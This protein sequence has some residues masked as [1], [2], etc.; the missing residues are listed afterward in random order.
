MGSEHLLIEKLDQFIR[1]FY[2]N[3][4]IRGALL[5]LAILAGCYLLF[6]MLESLFRFDTTVRTLLFYLF[7][8]IGAASLG[9]LILGPLL[10]YLH[11]GKRISRE[12]AARIIGRH[13]NEIQDKLLNALQLIELKDNSHMGVDLLTASID[14]KIKKLRV[15]SFTRTIDYRKNLKYLKFVIP[16]IAIIFL[17]YL[18]VPKFLFEP[19][20]RIVDYSTVYDL[21]LPFHLQV[22]NKN[23][24]VFQQDDFDVKV[25]ASGEEIPSEV[26]IRTDGFTYRMKKNSPLDFSYQFKSIQREATF[27]I[28]ANNYLSREYRIK[29]IPRPTILS[30][31]VALE[32]PPYTGKKKENLEN[33]GDLTV[34][35]GTVILWRW[36]TKDVENVVVKIG[37]REYRLEPSEE[38]LFYFQERC[39]Q[40]DRYTVIP[41]NR[42][43]S[44]TDSLE[45]KL[46]CLEDAYPSILVEKTT[47]P[48][49]PTG[50]FFNGRIRDDYGFTRLEFHYIIQNSVDTVD[51]QE[52]MNRLPA[53]K[54]TLEEVFYYSIDLNDYS[55]PPGSKMSY[56]FMI[57]DNDAI[58]GPKETKSAI[59]ETVTQ[60]MDQIAE[61]ASK[62]EREIE[63]KIE[64]LRDQARNTDKTIDQLK[65][66]LMEKETMDWQEKRELED[67]I[68]RNEE[69]LE[70][71]K[72]VKEENQRNI[73]QEERYLKTSQEI[74]EKKKRL[75]ELMEELMTDEMR[76]TLEELKQLMEQVDK[77]K[78]KE[79]MDQMKMTSRELEQQLDRN[80]ELF[81]QIEF[82]RK[83]EQSIEELRK[84]AEIQEQLQERTKKEESESK[85]RLYEQQKIGKKFDSLQNE[86][87]KLSEME[88]EL[89]QKVGIE[90]TESQQDSIQK[91]LNEAENNL[92]KEDKQKATQKQKNAAQQ[93]NQLADNLQ[94]MQQNSEIEQYAEDL[95]LIRQ[96]MENLI[97]ISFDQ[98]ELINKTR[99]ISRNDPRFQ[100]IITE[101]NQLNENLGPVKDS[102]RAIGKRQM[103]IQPI[104]T[105]ELN[106]IQRNIRETIESMNEK[107]IPVALTKQQYSM[108]SINNLAVLLD[109]AME[110]MNRNMNMSMQGGMSKMC[111]NPKMG[112]GKKSMKTLRQMQQQLSE[113]LEKIKNGLQKRKE[114]EKQKGTEGRMGQTG[115]ENINEEIAR[116]AAEQEAIREELKNYQQYLKEQGDMDQDNLLNAIKKI[117]ENQHDLINKK[118]T[119]ESVKRQQEILTRLLE[120]E[121]AEQKRDQQEKREAEEAKS[122][123]YSNPGTNL[124]YNKYFGRG[125]DVLNYQS[126]PVSV[127]YKNKAEKYLIQISQ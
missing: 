108:T 117:D 16:P 126:L 116:L 68:Q 25:T 106:D 35:K 15:I 2:K 11:L 5:S 37:E 14:Q 84:L 71:I 86:L 55:L 40:S 83:L 66:K 69:M 112:K 82:E 29:V 26:Y 76:K 88:K 32:Y 81:R 18:I 125:T 109:E 3:R 102:L 61:N 118:V 49:A 60:T 50:I 89:E 54:G 115:E 17:A 73:Q 27:R 56:Y 99:T 4:M 28:A 70:T 104:I 105:R 43:S 10:S 122:Q 110:Q 114:G 30:F 53:S 45:F 100:Q 87:S 113:Q 65:R 31:T 90:K 120:S 93:M 94:Q 42:Y 52:G 57:W 62:K 8:G 23:F 67:L 6:V 103:L 121:K 85:E 46:N 24:T 98:E 44:G 97:M 9:Y 80:Q 96:I 77:G 107:N 13:F 79:L 74:L 33:L 1:K 78:L 41:E 63:E 22:E 39:M 119:N 91:L 36:E 92:Q 21:P 72:K 19:T 95:H 47:S 123:K 48:E 34:P 38:N 51:N 59:W 64:T 7:V 124:E 111:H 101:Q 58:N 75:N 12:E 127:F 20:K